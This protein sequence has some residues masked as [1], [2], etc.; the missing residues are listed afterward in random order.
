MRCLTTLAE[1]PLDM[2][3]LMYW[4]IYRLKALSPVV[5]SY[6]PQY[7]SYSH[8]RWPEESRMQIEALTS[9]RQIPAASDLLE[10]YYQLIEAFG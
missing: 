2:E 7:G 1:T 8:P 5:L 9:H 4:L 3:I 6:P 10:L